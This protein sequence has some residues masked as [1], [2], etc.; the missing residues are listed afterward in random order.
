MVNLNPQAAA[1]LRVTFSPAALSE[2]KRMLAAHQREELGLRL[3]LKEAGGSCGGGPSSDSGKFGMGLDLP[4]AG[5]LEYVQDGMRV[6]LDPP[7]AQKVDGLQVDYDARAKGFRVK[8][9]RSGGC[10]GHC[11]CGG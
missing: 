10:G 6:I 5:D 2:L 11:G 1:E 3:Y 7:T 4:R 9:P 8:K